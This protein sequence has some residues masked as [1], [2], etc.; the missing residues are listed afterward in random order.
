MHGRHAG[1]QRF[2]HPT[3]CAAARPSCVITPSSR[4]QQDSALIQQPSTAGWS[5]A[6]VSETVSKVFTSR[7]WFCEPGGHCIGCRDHF[8]P[9]VAL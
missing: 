7:E 3:R 9:R 6:D 2:E 8:S 1:C 4:N 5:I